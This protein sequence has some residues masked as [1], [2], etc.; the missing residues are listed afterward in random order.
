MSPAIELEEKALTLVGEAKGLKIVDQP[1]YA[2]AA[3]R[4][5]NIAALRREIE[6]HHAPIKKAAHAAWQVV[7][8]AERTLLDPVAEA[9]RIYK[10]GIAIY[11]S[12]QRRIEAEARAK[13][14]AEA[15]R[16]AEERRERELEAAE[17]QGADAEEIASM[18]SEPLMAAPARVEPTFQ[19]A[20]GVSVAA[21]WKGEIVSLE[22]LVKAVAA[23]K[24]NIGL[25]RPNDTAIGHLAKATRGTLAI[26]G[27][28]FFSEPVVRAGRR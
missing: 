28:R 13:A 11:E 18:I 6:Q 19:Q 24:A 8:A 27:V 9:E 10:V 25:V 3:E 14:E 4:L 22:A 12:E 2:L 26:P 7:I 21:N 23:G 5:L 16:L 20:K 1:T 15:Q 17:A